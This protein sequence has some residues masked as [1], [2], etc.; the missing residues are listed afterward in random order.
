MFEYFRDLVKDKKIKFYVLKNISLKIKVTELDT[1]I[2]PTDAS[3]VACTI[4]DKTIL[5]TLDK[6]LLH[7]EKIEGQYKIKIL[8]PKELI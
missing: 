1:R 3:I 5:V 7:N 2:K 8:H 6:D 4:E